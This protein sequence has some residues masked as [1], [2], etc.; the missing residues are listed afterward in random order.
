MRSKRPHFSYYCFGLV[1]STRARNFCPGLN[2]TTRRAETGMLSPVFGLR[3]G[4]EALLRSSK[5]PKPDN[6]TSPP[7]SN[8]KRISSK[9]LPLM[10]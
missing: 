2:A 7:D 4:R 9:S 8:D 10:L 5:L 3:P 1:F 6:F